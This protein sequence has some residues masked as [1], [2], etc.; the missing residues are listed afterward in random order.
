METD[1]FVLLLAVI[2]SA[3]FQINLLWTAAVFDLTY[4]LLCLLWKICRLTVKGKRK[5]PSSSAKQD[6]R[7]RH[8]RK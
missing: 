7:L 1:L 8:R 4:R 3:V 5:S 2:V 6:G